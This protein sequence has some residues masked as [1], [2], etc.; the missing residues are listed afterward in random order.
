MSR[1]TREFKGKEYRQ[2]KEKKRLK[3]KKFFGWTSGQHSESSKA[4]PV[5]GKNGTW[6]S[7]ADYVKYGWPSDFR[8]KEE[9][10]ENH[11][12]RKKDEVRKIQRAKGS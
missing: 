11:R 12:K 3:P 6:S 4:V 9:I 1:T 8:A 7:G 2:E 5:P 10:D